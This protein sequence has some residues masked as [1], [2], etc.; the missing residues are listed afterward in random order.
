MQS[1]NSVVTS[2]RTL[3]TAEI[4]Y[5]QAHP[6]VG[7]TC[8]LSDLQAAWGISEDLAAGNKNGYRFKLQGCAAD[9]VDG[10]I[11]KYQL[12]PIHGWVSGETEQNK[13]RRRIAQ[14]SPM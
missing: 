10:P 9:K 1:E 2:L 8:S 7:Y 14:I 5:S 13:S 3:N 11:V 6:K 12:W 4:A